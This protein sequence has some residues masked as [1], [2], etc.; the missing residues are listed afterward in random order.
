MNYAHAYHAGNFADVL[1]HALLAF[2]IQHLK[3]KPAPFRVVDTHAGAGL[4]DLAGVEAGRTLEWADGVGRLLGVEAEPIPAAAASL[5]EPYLS[6]VREL[7]G[8]SLAKY[9]GSPILARR[10][11]RK[12]DRLIANELRPLDYAALSRIFASD[13]QTKVLNLDG[14]AA[15]KALLPP[16]E[17]RGLVLIDPPFE[18]RDEFD[19]LLDALRQ[20]QRRF[21]TGT[22]LIWYP[23][24][25]PALPAAFIDAAAKLV[26]GKALRLELLI[27]KPSDAARLNGCGLLVVNPP[28]TLAEAFGTL[29]AFFAQRLAQGAGASF[30]LDR[31]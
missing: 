25:N 20:A 1:K 2:C 9:P 13:A 22:L 16:Q 24:K 26:P 5:L 11:L 28:Y 12:G 17:R 27:R 8:G 21:A 15:L 3:K 30:G 19:R 23:I 29:G 14:C 7:N 31:L 10:L 6:V 4:Y 18:K